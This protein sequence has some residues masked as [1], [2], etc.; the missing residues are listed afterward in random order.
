MNMSSFQRPE[1][2]MTSSQ[3]PLHNN[4]IQLFSHWGTYGGGDRLKWPACNLETPGCPQIQLLF[5]HTPCSL[6]SSSSICPTSNPSQSGQHILMALPAGNGAFIV[7]AQDQEASVKGRVQVEVGPVTACDV[8]PQATCLNVRHIAVLCNFFYFWDR[9]R[10]RQEKEMA[11][12][13]HDRAAYCTTW[14]V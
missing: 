8:S 5:F 10:H 9:C 3:A 1:M 7:K 4:N 11:S 14:S 12:E 13:S 6:P 2:R